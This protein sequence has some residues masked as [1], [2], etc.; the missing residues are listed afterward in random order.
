MSDNDDSPGI[1]TT[2]ATA[3]GSGRFAVFSPELGQYVSGVMSKSEATK[4]AK[5]M[6]ADKDAFTHGHDL[7]ATEV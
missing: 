6:K 4:A 5:A 1:N 2:G 7:Q 3:E